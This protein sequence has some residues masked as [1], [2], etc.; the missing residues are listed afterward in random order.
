MLDMP[1]LICAIAVTLSLEL[2]LFVRPSVRTDVRPSVSLYVPL[3]VRDADC[4]NV[5]NRLNVS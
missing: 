2:G 3:S 5:L 4:R 1:L